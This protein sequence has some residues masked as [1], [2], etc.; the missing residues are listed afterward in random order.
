MLFRSGDEWK[1]FYYDSLSHSAD[2]VVV[3]IIDD[4]TFNEDRTA[5]IWEYIFKNR[6][7][8]RFVEILNDTIRFFDNLKELWINTKFVFPLRVN[9]GWK[10]DSRS[11]TNSVISKNPISVAAGHFTECYLIKKTW[12][13]LNNYGSVS[14]WFVPGIG[15]VKRHNLSASPTKAFAMA[16]N[17]WEL[18]EYKTE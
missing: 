12:N 1:Y 6:I 17:Y 9:K 3:S 10:G 2:T 14:T 13:E 8:H 7:E 5:K 15:I 11:D 16:N 18:L 4:T